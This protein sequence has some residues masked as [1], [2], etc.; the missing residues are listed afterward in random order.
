ML[1]YLQE[2]CTT[3]QRK[4]F[5][6][7]TYMKEES[8]RILD[9]TSEFATQAATHIKVTARVLEYEWWDEMR[10]LYALP[11]KA[12]FNPQTRHFYVES[13]DELSLDVHLP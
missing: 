7:F 10:R 9:V 3:E 12:L 2:R 6:Y 1:Q 11:E 4:E 5:L 13:V 8:L